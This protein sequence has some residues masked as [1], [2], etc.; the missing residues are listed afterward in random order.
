MKKEERRRGKE[1][2]RQVDKKQISKEL[3]ITS[4]QIL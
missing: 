4:L 1:D 3:E 2:G